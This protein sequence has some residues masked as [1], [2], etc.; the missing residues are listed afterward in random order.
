M[1]DIT[2]LIWIIL[3]SII[4][5]IIEIL[6]VK[7]CRSDNH[8]FYMFLALNFIN[9]VSSF[10]ISGFSAIVISGIGFIK[11]GLV[12]LVIGAVLLIKLGLYES[13]VRGK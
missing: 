13:L 9:V 10:I 5:I 11:T 3:F 1:T 12:L 4:F 7:L 6:I 2:Y 8:S